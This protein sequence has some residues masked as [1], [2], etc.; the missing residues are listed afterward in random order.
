MN[1]GTP[2]FIAL[3]ILIVGFSD[4]LVD[5]EITFSNLISIPC[6]NRQTDPSAGSTDAVDDERRA[7]W[8]IL[9]S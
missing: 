3:D 9:A 7:D 6:F 2:T 5:A 1:T 4:R 8:V